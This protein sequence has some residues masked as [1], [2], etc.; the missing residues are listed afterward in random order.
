MAEKA[1]KRVIA[2]PTKRGLCPLFVVFPLCRTG[3]P[4]FARN[5]EIGI[6]KREKAPIRGLFH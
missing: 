5:G 4:R 3:S 2:S 6:Y 1:S